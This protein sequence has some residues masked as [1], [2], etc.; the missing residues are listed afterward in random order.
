MT[1]YLGFDDPN[2]RGSPS[3]PRKPLSIQLMALVIDMDP[4]GITVQG[5]P[6]KRT[7]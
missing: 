2:S 6:G 3:N 4:E 7:E 5:V 1:Q